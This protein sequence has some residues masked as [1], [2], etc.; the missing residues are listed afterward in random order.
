VSSSI[1]VVGVARARTSDPRHPLARRAAPALLLALVLLALD[2]LAAIGGTPATARAAQTGGSCV[3]GWQEMPIP[4]GTFISTPFD[5]VS[6]DGEPA[7]I[8]GGAATGILALRWDGSA[9]LRAGTSDGGH[10]GLVGG[11]LLGDD[12]VLGVGYY[13]K[14]VGEGDGS[15]EPIS[16]RLA[17][18]FWKA[19]AVPD[20]AGPRAMLADVTALPDG[21]AW[22]VGTRLENGLLRAYAVR[23]SGPRWVAKDP[24]GGAGGL[25]AVERAPDG[26]IWAVGWRGTGRGVPRPAIV[27]HDGKAWRA[28]DVP[29]LPDGVAVLTDLAFRDAGDG[30]AVGYL[31]AKGSDVH[32][33]VL[34]RWDGR[35]WK[36]QA[37]PWADQG[38]ALPRSIAVGADGTVWVAGAQP[39]NDQRETRGFV[40][41]RVAGQWSLDVL[42]V[43]AGVRSEVMAVA[44][45]PRGALITASVAASLLIME[46]CASGTATARAREGGTRLKVSRMQARRR[47]ARAEAAEDWHGGPPVGNA[48]FVPAGDERD[49]LGKPVA[50]VGFVLEDRAAATGLAQTT[51]TFGGFA[52]DFDGNG[53]RDVF[54]SRHGGVLPRLAMGGPGGFSDAPTSA[55]SPVDR[56]GCD[57]ADVDRDG[58]RDIL[59]S[60]GAQRGKAIRRNELSLAP[61]KPDGRLVTGALGLSDPLGRGRHVAF[62]RLDGDAWPDVFIGNAPDRDDGLPGSNRFYR[63]ARGTFVPAPAVG[64]DTAHGTLCV[65]VGDVDGDGDEDLA[66]CSAYDFGRRAAGLRLLHNRGGRLVD[67]TASLGIRPIGDIDVSFADVDGDGLRDLI[68]LA[69]NLVRVSRATRSGYRTSFE[70]RTSAAVALA[71]GDVN[72]DGRAD[73]YIARGSDDRNSKDLLL[74]SERGGRAFTSVRLPHTYEGRADDVIALDHDLN[75]FADFV[76]LNG[77]RIPGP[78]QLIAAYPG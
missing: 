47:T 20:P 63:N 53:Y 41:R 38:A 21:G 12:L 18:T 67:V 59:C 10:R 4:D 58:N 57:S 40:A 31:A 29:A 1:R 27:R 64:L 13:R 75:G 37:L 5:I 3:G 66:Y 61:D 73:L 15:M 78:V 25:T 17:S 19:I 45:T 22:A 60:V 26:A 50:P 52:T 71:A 42:G 2:L 46:T 35:R 62:I 14:V 51:E 33:A 24:F 56:H 65:D 11:T 16:G 9:W 39:A 36:R 34:L 48:V 69:P 68:Q 44:T 74:I 32:R 7:W 76:V 30:Y 54:Y 70:A 28:V 77:R 8:L 6:R 23:R 43:P 72:G 49:R 55:F